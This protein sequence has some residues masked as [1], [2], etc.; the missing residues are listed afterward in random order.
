MSSRNYFNVR[1]R[2]LEYLE[3]LSQPAQQLDYE[4][5]AAVANVHGRLVSKFCDD[6]F[7][8]KSQQFLTAFTEKE[9]KDLARLYGLLIESELLLRAASVTDLVREP[10]WHRIARFAKQLA[11]TIDAGCGPYPRHIAAG[12]SMR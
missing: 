3:L 10:E 5:K 6:L 4:A 7:H 2:V 9:I 11:A 12:R 8:P 1:Q